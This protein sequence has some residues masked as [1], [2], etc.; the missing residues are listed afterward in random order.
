M[1]LIDIK[2]E[3]G[4]KILEDLLNDG[5]KKIREYSPVAFD[6]SIDFDSYVLKRAAQS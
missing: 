2:T 1:K 3:V 5:W 4:N 6:K